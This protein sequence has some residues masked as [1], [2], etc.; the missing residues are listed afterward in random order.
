MRGWGLALILS[1]APLLAAAEAEEGRKML[2]A[3]EQAEWSGVG[4]LNFGDAFCTG[5]LVAPDLVVTAAHCL[6]ARRTGA[7]RRPERTHFV[8]GYRLR[9]FLAHRKASRF[10][11]HPDYRFVSAAGADEIAVDLALVRLGAP[12][13]ETAPFGLAPGLA[14]GDGVSILSYG[15]DRPEI[16]SIQSGCGV[17]AR[18]G[19]VAVLA[20]DVTYGVSGAPVFR[21]VDGELKIVAVVSAMGDF[22]GRPHAFAVMLDAALAPLLSAP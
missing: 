8:A 3:H 1:L 5:A 18:F 13:T 20:C 12:I 22:R 7:E 16:P 10:T 6:F 2:G 11:I 15:R 17:T 14:V 9:K 19:A 21:E 4:R